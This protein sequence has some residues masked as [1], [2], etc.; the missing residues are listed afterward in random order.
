[1]TFDPALFVAFRLPSMARLIDRFYPRFFA[2][3][4]AL[5]ATSE[6]LLRLLI[7]ALDD[8]ASL[9]TSDDQGRSLLWRSA[10]YGHVDLVEELLS[11]GAPIPDGLISSLTSSNP[12]I[13][14]SHSLALDRN[15]CVDL[16]RAHLAFRE[17]DALSGSLV[18]PLSAGSDRSS[19]PKPR[20]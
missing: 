15:A 11:R 16:L 5:S 12:S 3:T 14:Y 6:G 10:L 8:G 1:M 9:S 17:R 2:K 13:A 4:R 18:E 20:L 7:T 19:A